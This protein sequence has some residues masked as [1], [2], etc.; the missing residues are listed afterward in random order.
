M[1][2]FHFLNAFFSILGA[3]GLLY[4]VMSQRINEGIVIKLGLMLIIS[5]LLVTAS[6]ILFT[7]KYVNVWDGLWNA[8]L[9]TRIGICMCVYGYGYRV[10]ERKHQMLR[11]S[12]WADLDSPNEG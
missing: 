10:R 3:G 11:K 4:V 7:P 5:G 2:S 9:V 12:D 1:E 6:L 8:G